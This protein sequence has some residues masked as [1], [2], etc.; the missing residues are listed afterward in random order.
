MFVS[1]SHQVGPEDVKVEEVAPGAEAK[2]K[3]THPPRVALHNPDPDIATITVEEY[4]ALKDKS[5][6]GRLA[7]QN[8]LQ[9]EGSAFQCN[10]MDES[11]FYHDTDLTKGLPI[12]SVHCC[13]FIC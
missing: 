3:A 2:S 13:V 9:V 11:D 5:V 7:A 8:P 1:Q 12:L 10:A 4:Q 6:F